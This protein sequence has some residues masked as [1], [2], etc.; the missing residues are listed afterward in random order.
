MNTGQDLEQENQ[1]WTEL[2]QLKICWKRSG[3]NVEIHQIFVDFQ[4]A[5]VGIQRDKL[6]ETIMFF[7]IPNKFLR[8]IKATV[9]DLTYHVKIGLTM[10]DG[11]KVENGLQQGN[12]LAPN[13]F[14]IALKC[15]IRQL[16]VEV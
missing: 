8:L 11:C 15:S 14:D 5:Y 16:S 13:L 7:G 3:N 2:S 6:Y 4:S 9:N 10:A 1:L 12:G